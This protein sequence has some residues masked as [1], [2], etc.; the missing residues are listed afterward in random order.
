MKSVF[1]YSDLPYE[2]V[3]SKA[4]LVNYAGADFRL[5][6]AKSTMIPSTKPIIA[7]CAART[8]CGKSQTTRA[9]CDHLTAQGKKVVAI[10]HPMPYGDLVKQAVQ[11]FAKLE[12]LKKA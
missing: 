1:A 12:D 2:Y 8:G 3:M 6:G 9:V 11:R 5:M 4:A 10:R 7:I